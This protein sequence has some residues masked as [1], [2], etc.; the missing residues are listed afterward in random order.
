[1]K[2]VRRR[3]KPVEIEKKIKDMGLTR[4]RPKIE[5]EIAGD[6]ITVNW[7]K[8]KKPREELI[9]AVKAYLEAMGY[10]VVSHG[11]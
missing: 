3:I 7:I 10:E 5:F 6:Q 1:M 8:P 9:K 4:Y 11:A 2:A